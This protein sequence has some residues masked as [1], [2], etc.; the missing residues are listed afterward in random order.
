MIPQGASI[1]DLPRDDTPETSVTYKIDFTTNR[2]VGRTDGLDAVKQAVFKILQ[3]ERYEYFCYS[4]DYGIEMRGL[5]GS[6]PS[7]VRSEL[8]RRIKEA[9]MQD[10][11]IS[12]VIDFQFDVNGE[13]VVMQFT[14]VSVFGSFGEEV[15]ERV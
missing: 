7:F 9:L 10:D 1:L 2:I 12:D 3:T 14:V 4:S 8:G 6:E 11:R 5:L 13:A 15:S